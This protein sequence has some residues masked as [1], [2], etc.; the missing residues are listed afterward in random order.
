MSLTVTVL[1]VVAHPSTAAFGGTFVHT[2]NADVLALTIQTHHSISTLG[3]RQDQA[4]VGHVITQVD[5]CTSTQY[6]SPILQGDVCFYGNSI[7][8]NYWAVSSSLTLDFATFG[9]PWFTLGKGA[10]GVLPTVAIGISS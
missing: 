6:P 10:F 3:P 4:R 8:T 1:V 5:M 7:G 2:E 9:I